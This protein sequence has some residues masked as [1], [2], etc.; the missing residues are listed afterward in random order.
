[1]TPLTLL[2]DQ[3]LNTFQVRDQ[4][5]ARMLRVLRLSLT[6][7]FLYVILLDAGCTYLHS[8]GKPA[9]M[10]AGTLALAQQVDYLDAPARE[11]MIIEHSN[12]TLFVSGYGQENDW[13]AKPDPSAAGDLQTVPRLWKSTDHGA[14]WTRVNVGTERDGAIGNSDVDL[15]VAPDGT[16]YFVTMGFDRKTQEGTHI[17]VGASTDIGKR[18]HWTMLS[19]KRFDDR[20][21]VAV[22]PDGAAHVIW[23]D[24]TG[25]YHTLSRDR[26]ITWSTPQL[27]HPEAGS[28]HMAIG[29]N[30][31]IAVRITPMYA[32]GN[33]FREGVDLIAVSTDGGVTWA[34]RPVP[35]KRDWAPLGTAGAIPRWVEP[36]AWDS[37]GALYL[38]WTDIKGVRLA[39]SLDRGESWRG[40]LIAESEVDALPYFPYLAARGPGELVATWYSGAGANLRGHVCRIQLEN[41]GTPI[42]LL[43]SPPLKTDSWYDLGKPGVTR[44]TAGEYLAASFLRD[45]Q[46]AAVGPIQNGAQKRFGFTFWSFKSQP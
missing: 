39:R 35:G 27:I 7:A 17:V 1:M 20:P 32:S 37:T 18:W 21:W 9:A 13:A 16:L 12:G 10:P 2:T 33:K 8:A 30:G 46:I 45:G 41:H 14:T 40:W 5:R 29:P 23:N 11:P 15:A 19:K 38:L 28:S 22:A 31:E 26:G 4:N 25:V 24:D 34:K 43:K 44:D 3:G 36:I 42:R 6:T